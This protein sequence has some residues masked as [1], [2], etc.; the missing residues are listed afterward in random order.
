[1]PRAIQLFRIST[2][3]GARTS[4]VRDAGEAVGIRL[5][6]VGDIRIVVTVARRGLHQGRAGDARLVHGGDHLLGRHRVLPRPVRLLAAERRPGIAAVVARD[7]VRVDVVHRLG[8][9]FVLSF[10]GQLEAGSTKSS[11]S[12]SSLAIRP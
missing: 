10:L 1:M 9:L 2:A 11:R 8:H 3:S 7:D 4:I 6:R 12:G 5:D